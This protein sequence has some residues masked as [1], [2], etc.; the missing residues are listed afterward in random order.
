DLSQF[1]SDGFCPELNKRSG[2]S[3]N[4]LYF[5]ANRDILKTNRQ[6]MLDM[7][8]IQEIKNMFDET[9]DS[10]IFDIFMIDCFLKME[11]VSKTNAIFLRIKKANNNVK[12]KYLQILLDLFNL[13]I[14]HLF[15]V[16]HRENE[17]LE[18]MD[19]G[20]KNM[21]KM[22]S[23]DENHA[24]FMY[25]ICDKVSK[26]LFEKE[27]YSKSLKTLKELD[28]LTEYL[29]PT[30]KL[31]LLVRK[32]LLQSFEEKSYDHSEIK[33]IIDENIYKNKLIVSLDVYESYVQI[34]LKESFATE[35]SLSLFDELNTTFR[36][37]YENGY[38]NSNI[39][40]LEGNYNEFL[41][42]DL[43]IA[44]NLYSKAVNK[45]IRNYNAGSAL[46]SI[47][48][49]TEKF[50]LAVQFIEKCTEPSL[51]YSPKWAN[52]IMGLE[53]LKKEMYVEAKKYI[54]NVVNI[55]NND[56]TAWE[57][58]GLCYSS[59]DIPQASIKAFKKALEINPNSFYGDYKIASTLQAQ[60]KYYEA[61]QYFECLLQKNSSYV[62]GLIEISCTYVH[63]VNDLLDNFL[64]N[65]ATIYLQK[66]LDTLSRALYFRQDM[67]SIWHLLGTLFNL[68]H[69]LSLKSI[70]I[71]I[72]SLIQQIIPK[73]FSFSE[74]SLKFDY[75]EVSKYFFAKAIALNDK[76]PSLWANLALSYYQLGCFQSNKDIEKDLIKENFIQALKCIKRAI[77]LDRNDYK[78]WNIMGLI[79]FY[80]EKYSS[81]QHCFIKGLN[82]NE[83]CP[84]LL[85]NL[86]TMHYSIL[87]TI[88]SSYKIWTSCQ[89]RFPEYG[90]CWVG[91]ANIAH[92]V[93]HKDCLDL[94]RHAN[95]IKL[96]SIGIMMHALKTLDIFRNPQSVS[97][98]YYHY[99]ITLANVVPS[100]IDMLMKCTIRNPD[101]QLAHI[102]LGLYCERAHLFD[103]SEISL[104]TA[105]NLSQETLDEKKIF[106]IKNNLSRVYWKNK[107]P[108]KALELYESH[109]QETLD[110]NS[111]LNIV[112]AFF[113]QNK[114]SEAQG[115]LNLASEKFE[116]FK[117]DLMNLKQYLYFAM[118]EFKMLDN[119]LINL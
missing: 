69:N 104:K 52:L 48:N 49:K 105:L 99:C 61:V 18:A 39:L 60:K 96:T 16:V 66:A 43:D 115:V 21:A 56:Y 97:Q 80:L 92:K 28:C 74:T 110:Y 109:K 78:L 116:D 27:N 22:D 81:A 65:K 2:V 107:M 34:L 25:I 112:G 30:F 79:L 47:F 59:L 64:D 117:T 73:K 75:I 87:S 86:G 29:V 53:F 14:T 106:S 100:N 54:L 93:N 33:E 82:Q 72:P 50:D 71:K 90:L 67:A 36:Y 26:I 98:E 46:F 4:V 45:N 32:I 38:Q 1:C 10:L 101:S 108:E 102:L 11:E 113:I 58:L 7:D 15:G 103:M 63:I 37:L 40:F 114:I 94:L 17:L 12:S 91:M 89:H 13:E 42:E 111:L 3:R 83:I 51:H 84:E 8:L 20:I 95:D 77:I 76:I 88:D 19:N 70:K 44:I 68:T 5:V 118:N 62:P 23:K 55:D 6:S 9:D 31:N 119:L 35:G 41:I 85:S 57:C 24:N